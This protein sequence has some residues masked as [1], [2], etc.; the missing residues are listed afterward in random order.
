MVQGVCGNDLAQAPAFAQLQDGT[1]LVVQDQNSGLGLYLVPEHASESVQKL[2]AQTATLIS[3]TPKI[4]QNRIAL[5]AEGEAGTRM[6]TYEVDFSAGEAALVSEIPLAQGAGMT[7][8]ALAEDELMVCQQTAASA[9]TEPEYEVC[10]YQLATGELVQRESLGEQP[11]YPICGLQSG[12]FL[13]QDAE[14]TLFAVRS[15]SLQSRQVLDQMGEGPF[16]AACSGVSDYLVNADGEIYAVD[17]QP[18][19][20]TAPPTAAPELSYAPDYTSE[21]QYVNENGIQV[22]TSYKNDL[23][24]MYQAEMIYAVFEPETDRFRFQLSYLQDG[25]RYFLESS[26]RWS[27]RALLA[28]SVHEDQQAP[29]AALPAAVLQPLTEQQLLSIAQTLYDDLAAHCNG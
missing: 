28:Y 1:V 5:F 24:P 8:Y 2:S 13:C 27:D 10:V 22:L 14:G 20:Q 26:F 9:G 7:E 18:P 6:L 16:A 19:A 11:V 25:R 23:L 21:N 17:A 4:H 12:G 3:V 15:D 29:D